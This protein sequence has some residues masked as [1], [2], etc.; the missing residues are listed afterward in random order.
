MNTDAVHESVRLLPPDSVAYGPKTR[1]LE[2]HQ[3]WAAGVND[4]QWAWRIAF[5]HHQ[6]QEP[7]PP[8]IRD[9]NIRRAYRY[10]QGNRD[11]QMAMVHGIRT[12]LEYGMT[13]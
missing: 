10:L 9:Q 4:P 12:S 7:L 1:P 6:S 13:R 8:S 11:D 2:A 3:R 5:G